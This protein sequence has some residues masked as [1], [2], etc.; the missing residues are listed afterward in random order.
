MLDF[1]RMGGYL[2]MSGLLNYGD[3][4]GWPDH[5]NIK[6]VPQLADEHVAA[7]GVHLNDE[8]DFTNIECK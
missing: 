3:E 6:H 4:E 8:E 7:E 5:N 1:H 2:V